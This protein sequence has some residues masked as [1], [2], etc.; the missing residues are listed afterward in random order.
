[1]MESMRNQSAGC[2]GR[3]GHDGGQ[4]VNIPER[5]HIF[6]IVHVD[7]LPSIL[8]AD[9][10]LCDAEVVKS[11]RPGTCIGL[12]DIKQRRL[13]ELTLTSHPGLYVGECVPFY[14]CPRSVMLYLIHMRNHEL[15]YR[16][17][18]DS[19]VHLV[20]NLHE[21]VIWADANSMRWAFTTS[22]AGSRYFDDYA[23]LS[24]LDAIDWAAVHAA[25]WS[26][27][28]DGKQAEFLVER[29]FPWHLVKVIGV[30][31]ERIGRL[32]A[33]VLGEAGHKPP[34]KILPQW[35]Y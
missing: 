29:H 22:N 7:R 30:Y 21:V 3:R 9:G 6:H 16:G 31:S 24:Q 8:A 2:A 26:A 13:H 35:Y 20:A 28:K 23:D 10:L 4:G 25:S 1:M 19:I 17:G 14:F 18:Q 34:I 15:T 27:C 33:R 12:N 5:I 11:Q 32:V